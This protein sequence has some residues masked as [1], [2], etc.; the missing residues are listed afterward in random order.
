MSQCPNSAGQ[1]IQS[2]CT[3]ELC[4]CISMFQP[5]YTL[6]KMKPSNQ[7]EKQANKKNPN[8]TTRMKK[9][10]KKPHPNIP[11]KQTSFKKKILTECSQWI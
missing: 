11:I 7:R 5:Y 2:L 3:S 9:K 1:F 4:H 6:G 8:K 10:Q